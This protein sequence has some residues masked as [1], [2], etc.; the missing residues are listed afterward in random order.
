MSQQQWREV[1]RRGSCVA[2]LTLAGIFPAPF[3]RYAQPTQLAPTQFPEARLVKLTVSVTDAQGRTVKGLK[4]EDFTVESDKR[5]QQITFFSY[6]DEPSSVVF[7]ID[8]S[9]SMRFQR[10]ASNRIELV[11]EAFPSFLKLSNPNSE[12]SVIGFSREAR[13]WLNWTQNEAELDRVAK[14]IAAESPAGHTALF[15]ACVLGIKQLQGSRHARRVLVLFTD[16]GDNESQEKKNRL[17][18]LLQGEDILVY[19]VNIG[20]LR[21]KKTGILAGEGSPDLAGEATLK[22]LSVQSGG[23]MLNARNA[24]GL[25][26][27][28]QFTS[29][30]IRHQY[31]IGFKPAHPGNNKFHRLKVKLAS[32]LS[33]GGSSKGMQVHHRPGYGTAEAGK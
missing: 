20:E 23:M 14:Q 3:P 16:G 7:L 22:E 18:R 9:G 11:A 26:I 33:I 10:S 28:V 8:L 4:Q 15:D 17:I 21:P 30:Q 2:L 32:R 25:E 5:P 29:V 19:A 1:L 31:V 13:V 24:R 27:L 6:R 12:F